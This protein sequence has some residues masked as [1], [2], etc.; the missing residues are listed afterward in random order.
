MPEPYVN[1]MY[2]RLARPVLDLQWSKLEFY[3]RGTSQP[4]MSLS[5]SKTVLCQIS[6]EA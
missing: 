3:G 2:N 1:Y 6:I 4:D 5:L